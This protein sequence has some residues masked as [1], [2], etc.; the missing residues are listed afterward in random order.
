MK[1]QDIYNAW[2]EKNMQIDITEDFADSVMDTIRRHRKHRLKLLLDLQRFIEVFSHNPITQA[3][4]LV[5]GT[6]AGVARI[7]LV[8]SMLSAV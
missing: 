5:A 6:T 3:A 4:L 1:N 8:F 2:K 7:A